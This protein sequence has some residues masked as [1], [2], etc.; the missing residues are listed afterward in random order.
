MISLLLCN[1]LNSAI[2]CFIIY[3]CGS[4]CNSTTQM[5][6]IALLSVKMNLPHQIT[7]YPENL[8]VVNQ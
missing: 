8:I 6:F 1:C 4:K 5:H 2:N 7:G 3:H